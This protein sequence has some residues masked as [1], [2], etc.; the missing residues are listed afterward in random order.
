MKPIAYVPLVSLIV[1]VC[2]TL[3]F[4]YL[5]DANPSKKGMETLV[6]TIWG[7]SIIL[8]L[9]VGFK[10]QRRK[11][12]YRTLRPVQYWPLIGF[13]AAIFTKGSLWPESW[14]IFPFWIATS[15]VV[16]FLVEWRMKVRARAKYP[17]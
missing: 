2:L 9:F 5:I 10:M 14:Y 1:A 4:A 7:A 8:G 11:K 16:G 6:P 13:L 3:G 15:I 17:A 12:P